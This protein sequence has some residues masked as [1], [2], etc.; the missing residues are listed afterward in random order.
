MNLM[1]EKYY[2]KKYQKTE[3]V[4]SNEAVN[5]PVAEIP[6]EIQEP[7]LI[8]K[9]MLE[10]PIEDAKL[11]KVNIDMIYTSNSLSD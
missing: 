3:N 6:A 8:I 4:P 9:I 11:F 7:G 10:K 1:Q 2:N 5:T